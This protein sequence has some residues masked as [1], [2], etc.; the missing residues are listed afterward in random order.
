M[1][2]EAARSMSA[3]ERSGQVEVDR[4][5]DQAQAAR[6]GEARGGVAQALDDGRGRGRCD[7]KHGSFSRGRPRLGDQAVGPHLQQEHAGGRLHRQ[8]DRERLAGAHPRRCAGRVA[9]ERE[10][11]RSAR[12]ARRAARRDDRGVACE[13][14]RGAGRV[15]AGTAR[16]GL[17][18]RYTCWATTATTSAAATVRRSA[19]VAGRRSQARHRSHRSG[20]SSSARTCW[21]AS[22]SAS[23]SRRPSSSTRVSK[24]AWSSRAARSSFCRSA[25]VSESVA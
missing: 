23:S 10:P 7:E 13:S 24:S 6:P 16:A 15:A 8:A 22:G 17:V 9:L 21:R 5:D 18:A 14:E 20:C 25:S 4:G 2:R 19:T 3:G 11:C 12:A 1:R